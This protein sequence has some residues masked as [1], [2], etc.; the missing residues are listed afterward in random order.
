VKKVLA[1]VDIVAMLLVACC[2]LISCKNEQKTVSAP[3]VAPKPAVAVPTR[4]E[5]LLKTEFRAIYITSWTAGISRF[6]TLL[7]MVTRSHLN[8]MV[9][10]I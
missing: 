4:R 5:Q 7:D 10:D 9:I 3:A 8:A 2:G 6:N 1:P